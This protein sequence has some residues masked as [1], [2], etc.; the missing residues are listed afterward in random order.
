MPKS[1]G[2]DGFLLAFAP[3][4][5]DAVK[6]FGTFKYEALEGNRYF[7]R[8]IQATSDHLDKFRVLAE[9]GNDLIPGFDDDAVEL[10]KNGYSPAKYSRKFAA[11]AECSVNEL[12]AALDGI[13][14]VIYSVYSKIQ[15]VQK[16]S[17]SKLFSK[18]KNNEYGAGFP[19]AIIDLLSLAHDDWFLELRKYRTEFTHGSL[20]SCS[21][22]RYTGKISYMHTG[23]GDQT[24]ALIIDDFIEYINKVYKEVLLLQESI[25]EFLY[26]ELPLK[27]TKVLCGFYTG[28]AYMRRIEPEKILTINSGICDSSHYETKCPLSEKCGAYSR[29]KNITK[30]SV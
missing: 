30:P 5:W 7:N 9:L 28:L 22:D 24:K 8:G 19:D 13:R 10:D 3:E 25:F 6:K 4:Q 21:K 26:S 27:P 17:T 1:A 20:G 29:V 2:H 15:G 23:L 12:Y 11:I 14:D 16:K 18:A